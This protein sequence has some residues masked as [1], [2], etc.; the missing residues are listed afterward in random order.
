MK[1]IMIPRT[2]KVYC[3]EKFIGKGQFG[4]VYNGFQDGFP[5]VRY[6]IKMIPRKIKGTENVI[7]ETMINR[8]IDIMWRC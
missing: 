7:S 3:L 6:A 8:E 4:D 1:R 2:N 5:E